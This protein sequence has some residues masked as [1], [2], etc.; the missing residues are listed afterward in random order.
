[1]ILII[2]IFVNLLRNIR[3]FHPNCKKFHERNAD[4]FGQQKI[5]ASGVLIL[6]IG[7]AH[8]GGHG[9]TALPLSQKFKLLQLV[10]RQRNFRA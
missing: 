9:V 7:V 3:V 4:C 10:T 6:K 1:M 8:C 2:H 5:D